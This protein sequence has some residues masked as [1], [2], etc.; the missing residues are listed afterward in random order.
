MIN[1]KTKQILQV[2]GILLGVG[3]LIY[4]CEFRDRT[5][6][7]HRYIE[8]LKLDSVQH[9][10]L[11]KTPELELP[12]PVT[13]QADSLR[14]PFGALANTFPNGEQSKANESN[15]L[16]AYSL[17]MLKFVGTLSQHGATDAFVLAPDGMIYQVKIGSEIGDH[18][19]KVVNVQ[20]EQL[21][22][23]EQHVNGITN[24]QHV[25]T[26]QLKEEH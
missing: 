21:E 16:L 15:P 4:S 19:G 5:I 6:D 23:M 13:Y 22:I 10:K 25:V 9:L 2:A 14:P 12:A 17:S 3:L 7:L 20:R 8:Q 24:N 26:L 18:H 1:K 11:N